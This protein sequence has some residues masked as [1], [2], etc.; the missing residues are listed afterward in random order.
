[1]KL[2]VLPVLP[3]LIR[4]LRAGKVLIQHGQRR[5]ADIKTVRSR[6]IND[7]AVSNKQVDLTKNFTYT[8][9][10][11]KTN[12]YGAGLVLGVKDISS[13]DNAMKNFIH[14]IADPSNVYYEVFTDG[15]GGG[16]YGAA[17]GVADLTEYTLS[18]LNMMRQRVL[19]PSILMIL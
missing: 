9:K 4:T 3:V 5:T 6:R 8:V 15:T 14:F 1:M 19:H 13:R 10:V 17:H 2:P 7:F 12:G 18:W 11:K 16:T